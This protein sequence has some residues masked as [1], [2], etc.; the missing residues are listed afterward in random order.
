MRGHQGHLNL[1]FSGAIKFFSGAIA[2]FSCLAIRCSGPGLLCSGL[3]IHWSILQQVV[4]EMVSLPVLQ[5]QM[6]KFH[7]KHGKFHKESTRIPSLAF[8]LSAAIQEFH[9]SAIIAGKT[10]FTDTKPD[11]V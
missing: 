3:L 4:P 5:H 7:I 8:S 2:P 6:S 1:L 10:P 9:Y 11:P